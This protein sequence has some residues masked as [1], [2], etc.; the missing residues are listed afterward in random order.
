L[1][2]ALN[3]GVISEKEVELYCAAEFARNDV[4]QVDS[5]SFEEYTQPKLYKSINAILFS[6]YCYVNLLRA[7]I[8]FFCLPPI[9][10]N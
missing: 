7:H 6:Y 3:L 9:L 10:K 1:G 8:S 2:I 5:L 4:I